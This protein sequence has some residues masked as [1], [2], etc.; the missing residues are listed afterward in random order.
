VCGLGAGLVG[1]RV[2]SIAACRTGSIRRYLRALVW[3]I[4]LQMLCSLA[5]LV[6][7]MTAST[8]AS[9]LTVTGIAANYN[10]SS[11][12]YQQPITLSGSGLSSIT[13][14]DWYCTAPNATP[15]DGSP[16]AWNTG[17]NFLGKFTI[18]SDSSATASP[19]LLV[20]GDPTGQ[21]QWLVAIYAGSTSS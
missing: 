5:A 15:C 3:P 6:A 4:G 7:A 1:D 13:E 9:A 16:Y 8:S 19:Q 20:S 10:T 11:A 21:Y 2:L 14:I 18:H 12:P 17:N